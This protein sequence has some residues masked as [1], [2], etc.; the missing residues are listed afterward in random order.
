MKVSVVVP[1]YNEEKNIEACLRSLKAQEVPAD[2]IIVVDNNSKDKTEEI[3]KSFGVIVVREEKQGITPARNRG[4]DEAQYE[5]IARTDADVV[6]PPDWIKKI[7]KNFEAKK[8]DALGGPV[9]YSDSRVI[10]RSPLLS[11]LFLE[12]LRVFSKGRR[13]FTGMNM[14]LTKSMWLRVRD[15]TE[16]SDARVHEDID[17]SLRIAKVG[18]IMGYDKTLVVQT[19]AR[20]MVKNPLSF[21]IEYPIRLIKTFLVNR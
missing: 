20:R 8:I 19:S 17:L 10:P 12:S 5:I 2:E 16:R 21:F 7:K 11:A 9:S 1:A 13:H 14:S 15:M 4:F 3:A 6:V 18:G